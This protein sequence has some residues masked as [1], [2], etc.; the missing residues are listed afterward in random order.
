M[1]AALAVTA[2]A[3]AAS[4]A[5]VKVEPYGMTKDGKPVRAFTLV[6]DKGASPTG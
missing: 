3:G 4:A 5:E 1:A 2:F 6:N